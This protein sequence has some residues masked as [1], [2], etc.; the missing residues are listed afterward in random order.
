LKPRITRTGL[1]VS[2]ERYP[3]ALCTPADSSAW[4]A[5]L[6]VTGTHLESSIHRVVKTLIERLSGRTQIL[7]VV[8]GPL[9]IAPAAAGIGEC[10][11]EVDVVWVSARESDRVRA[12]NGTARYTC[13]ERSRSLAW[14]SSGCKARAAGKLTR[15]SRLWS[16]LACLNQL[17]SHIE[18]KEGTNRVAHHLPTST[19]G[20][21]P[22]CFLSH[23]PATPSKSGCRQT[24]GS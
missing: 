2:A 6:Q 10:N 16:I 20:I 15:G 1:R 5:G 23:Q 22:Y 12:V 11:A 24:Y 7:W 19:S 3:S 8:L 14:S 21:A 18:R 13:Y 17:R 9:K 4:L